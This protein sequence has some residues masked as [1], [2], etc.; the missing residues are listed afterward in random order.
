MQCGYGSFCDYI[1][2]YSG[3]KTILYQGHDIGTI[4]VSNGLSDR[5]INDHDKDRPCYRQF[6]E[7]NPTVR[8]RWDQEVK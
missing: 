2:S 1:W 4:P 5:I 8:K 6:I 3:D 7:A